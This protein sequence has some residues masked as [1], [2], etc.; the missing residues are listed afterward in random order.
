MRWRRY[1]AVRGENETASMSSLDTGHP[2]MSCSQSSFRDLPHSKS[3][4]ESELWQN[5]AD[6]RYLFYIYGLATRWTVAL[7]RPIFKGE[8]MLANLSLGLC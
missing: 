4:L 1:V 5:P 7:K 8:K 3:K 2:H 6:L